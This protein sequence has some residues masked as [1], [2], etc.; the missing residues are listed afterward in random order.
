MIDL[1]A[2]KEEMQ[3]QCQIRFEQPGWLQG[4]G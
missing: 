4:G 1:K 2:Y 3:E